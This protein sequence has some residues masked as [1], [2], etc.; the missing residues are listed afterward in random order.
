[1]LQGAFV[2]I[3]RV[4]VYP[5]RLYRLVERGNEMLHRGFRRLPGAIAQDFSHGLQLVFYKAENA[6]ITDGS[7]L[8][9]PGT[10]GG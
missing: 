2:T 6:P 7:S 10:F 1:M 8:C 5:A 4:S 9:L 3:G